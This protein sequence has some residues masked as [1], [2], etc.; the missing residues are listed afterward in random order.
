[1]RCPNCQSELTGGEKFCIKCGTAIDDPESMIVKPALSVPPS[2]CIKCGAK[3][4][5]TARFCTK[6]GNPVDKSHKPAGAS[7]VVASTAKSPSGPVQNI[8]SQAVS[9]KDIA[10]KKNKEFILLILLVI[11]ALIVCILLA[12][13]ASGVLSGR[14][15]DTSQNT[16]SSGSASDAD[17]ADVNEEDDEEES[18]DDAEDEEAR[19]QEIAAIMEEIDAAVSEGDTSEYIS[20]SYKNALNGYVRLAS[21]YDMADDISSDASEVFEKYALQVRNSV[22]LLDGQKVSSGLYIQSR[23]YYDE[24]MGCADAM[25]DAGIKFDDCGITAESNALTETYRDKYIYAVNEITSR[26]NWSRDEAWNLMEDAACILDES[27][28]RVLFA[29]DDPDDPMRLRY[30]YSLAWKTRKDIETGLAN[31]EL[32]YPGALARIDEVL[33]ET[34]YNLMLLYDGIFY[35]NMAGI[36]PSPYSEAFESETA[37]IAEHDQISV[38]L[39]PSESDDT[40]FDLNHFW[41]FNDISED[42]NPEYQVSYK[43]GTS[44]ATRQWIRDNIRVN[45]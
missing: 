14:N 44:S 2:F 4:Q 6:C 15:H 35:S 29:E 18:E 10:K 13:K 5:P 25:T 36:D 11:C 24:I 45:R 31:G 3:M 12:L 26:E 8:P 16:G 1:M 40:H 28:N 20:E 38:V 33:P 7:S 30:I 39:N 23:M 9:E 43:N 41:I 34:D 19:Q 37:I 17:D 22:A 42:A 32:D 27:G 21:D